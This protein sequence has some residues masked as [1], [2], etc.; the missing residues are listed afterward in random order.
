MVINEIMYHPDTGGDEF[1]EL[2]NITTN[3]VPLFDPANTN[4]TWRL[5]GLGFYFPENVI[6]G[7]TELMLLVAMDPDAFRAKYSIPAQVQI[8]GPYLGVL[9]G[10]GERLELQRPDVPDTNAL[11]YITVDEVRYNDKSPWPIAAD[12]SGPSLQRRNSA[13]Y[14][15]DPANW[16]AA[17]ATPS[18]DF[19]GGQSP[20]IVTQPQ[21]Q[22]VFVGQSATFSVVANSR[23]GPLTYRWR[24]NGGDISGANG[25]TL[26][27]N[28]V[29][30]SQAGNYSVVVFNE[31]GSVGSAIATLTVRQPPLITSQPAQQFVKP[32]SN[33]LFTVSATGNGFLHYQW[34]RESTNILNATNIT[35]LITNAQFV[36]EGVYRVI[37]TDSIG[38]TISSP[39][40][41][42]ILVD[43]DFVQQ[44]VSLSAVTG[45]VFTISATV[46]NTATLP[47]GF[48]LRRNNVNQPATHVTLNS[49]TVFFN[50]LAERPFTNYAIIATNASLGGGSGKLSASAIITLL[51]DSDGD[52]LP[53]VWENA[54]PSAGDRN[55][56][57]DGDGASNWAEYIAGTDPT[58]ALS[59]LKVELTTASNLA[60]VR[61]FALSN[62]TYT[63]QFTDSL[64]T[65]PW[66]KFIDLPARVSNR[67]ESVRDPNWRPS[68]YYRLATPRQN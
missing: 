25:P 52:G 24:F 2:K 59:Y 64:N 62:K 7:P 10:S 61:F 23:P 49:R 39:A 33:A 20:S 66:L 43:P 35:L 63:I 65:N 40:Q 53:D 21:S 32:G 29:T 28:A 58:N 45:T 8:F 38:P 31:A 6:L 34:Q 5:N 51:D 55:G 1:L 50:I 57:A 46:T 44:P 67:V 60:T 41:L 18:A 3:P 54:Y 13:A 17:V 47:M 30:P 14:G 48:R 4:N 11:A 68:R 56:D 12:G 26:T 16:E 36:N 42:L 15:N 19:I 27:I 37:V 22:T 9:Q